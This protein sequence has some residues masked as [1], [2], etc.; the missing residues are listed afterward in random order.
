MVLEKS[1]ANAASSTVVGNRVREGWVGDKESGGGG[2]RAFEGVEGEV[3]FGGPVP[4]AFLL[5]ELVERGGERGKVADELPEPTS[6]T[7]EAPEGRQ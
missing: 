1:S 5:L 4:F 6:E 2:D 3:A 7:E